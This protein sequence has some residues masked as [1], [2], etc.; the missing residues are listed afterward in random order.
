MILV[1]YLTTQYPFTFHVVIVSF[2]RLTWN[3]F[4]DSSIRPSH[5]ISAPRPHW[6][7]FYDTPK[8]FIERALSLSL[9]SSMIM[10]AIFSRR[11]DPRSLASIFLSSASFCCSYST[12]YMTTMPDYTSTILIDLE[13]HGVRFVLLGVSRSLVAICGTWGSRDLNRSWWSN[14][15]GVNYCRGCIGIVK[16]RTE[17]VRLWVR[18]G[19][20][21]WR[22]AI[23]GT[24]SGVRSVCDKTHLKGKDVEK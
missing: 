15:W 9:F 5:N 20:W 22:V 11:N 2:T 12:S 16:A 6:V 13:E 1:Q 19:W 4:L 10:A 23:C 17:V 3:F 24:W 8:L 21:R 14:C 7:A 18:L